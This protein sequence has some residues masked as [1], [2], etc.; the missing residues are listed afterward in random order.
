MKLRMRNCEHSFDALFA[1]E[2]RQQL[3]TLLQRIRP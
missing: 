1:P 2:E 3:L